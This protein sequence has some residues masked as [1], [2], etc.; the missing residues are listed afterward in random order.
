MIIRPVCLQVAGVGGHPSRLVVQTHEEARQ[1]DE[2]DPTLVR[3][4]G[5][6]TQLLQRGD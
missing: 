2:L 1:L 6:W 3:A 5:Q 4:V